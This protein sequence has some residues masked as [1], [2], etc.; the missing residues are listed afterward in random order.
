[1]EMKVL[2]SVQY[3]GHEI[4]LVEDDFMQLFAVIVGD[5]KLYASIADAKRVVR[6]EQPKF[7]IS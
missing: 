6:G 2:K 3:R 7:E 1:M 4:Q 5:G